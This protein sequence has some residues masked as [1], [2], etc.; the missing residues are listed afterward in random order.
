MIKSKIFIMPKF[1]AIM[2]FLFLIISCNNVDKKKAADQKVDVHTKVLN[3][4]VGELIR[5]DSFKSQI[6]KENRQDPIDS[7]RK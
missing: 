2:S 1:L 3:D 4:S 5:L 7:A 6:K